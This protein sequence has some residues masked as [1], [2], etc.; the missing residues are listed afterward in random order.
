MAL[1]PGLKISKREAL[2]YTLAATHLFDITKLLSQSQL[3]IFNYHRIA[4]GDPAAEP[5][6][7]EVYGPNEENFRKEL[8]CMKKHADPI[9]EADLIASVNGGRALPKRSFFVTFDDGYRDN[10]ER[11][12]P[13]LKELG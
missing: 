13:I 12:L 7:S 9:S 10:F 4:G 8:L 3:S 1:I 2:A 5:F 11:A 6:D